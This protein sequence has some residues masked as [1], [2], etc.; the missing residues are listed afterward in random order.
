MITDQVQKYV[1]SGHKAGGAS[2]LGVA[3]AACFEALACVFA[4]AGASLEKTEDDTLTKN[5][6]FFAR[7]CR[8]WHHYDVF[9][10]DFDEKYA[11]SL[12][13]CH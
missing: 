7:V 12:S 4:S 11:I 8:F 10:G 13:R 5:V 1:F 9:S 6:R 3:C 2:P